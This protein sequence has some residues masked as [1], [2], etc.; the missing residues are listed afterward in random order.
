MTLFRLGRFILH[1]GA[2]SNFKIDADALTDEDIEAIACILAE[3]IPPFG[4]V[5]S[6]P[7]GG[8]R[9]AEALKPYR[10]EHGL[11]LIVD[12]V[13]T[14]GASFEKKRNG[15]SNVVGVAI[16]ARGECPSWVL[17]LFRMD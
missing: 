7:K 15:R 10:V 4:R 13:V 12:D 6:I 2:E 1:S 17:P 9:L 8:D 16:F 3:K 14:T 5:E 11:T